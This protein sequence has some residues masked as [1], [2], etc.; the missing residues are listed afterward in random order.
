MEYAAVARSAAEAMRG[1]LV[2]ERERKDG[3]VVDC[4]S[5]VTIELNVVLLRVFLPS[6]VCL[7][8]FRCECV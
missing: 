1:G 6:G 4:L 5:R 3:W 2:R 8:L 7:L